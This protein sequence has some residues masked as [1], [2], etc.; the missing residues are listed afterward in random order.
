MASN[1][2]I[3]IIRNLVGGV[4]NDELSTATAHVLQNQISAVTNLDSIKKE[5]DAHE[6]KRQKQPNLRLRPYFHVHDK[7]GVCSIH[8]LVHLYNARAGVSKYSACL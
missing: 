8:V 1:P 3:A 4:D 6:E 5:R 7:I 2:I